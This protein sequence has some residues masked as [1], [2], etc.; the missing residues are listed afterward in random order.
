MSPLFFVRNSSKE[1]SSAITPSNVRDST[2][3]LRYARAGRTKPFSCLKVTS[4]IWI[5]TKASPCKFWAETQEALVHV[6]ERSER[7]EKP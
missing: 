7:N 1:A 5:V 3:K 6:S 2:S 4:D